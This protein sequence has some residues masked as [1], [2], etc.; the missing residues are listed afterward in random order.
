MIII[1]YGSSYVPSKEK[2]EL[3]LLIDGGKVVGSGQDTQKRSFKAFDLFS[4]SYP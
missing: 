3:H 1:A 2:N 4:E